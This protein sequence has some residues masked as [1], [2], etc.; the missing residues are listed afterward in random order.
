VNDAGT[1][2]TANT[3]VVF[4]GTLG[5]GGTLTATNIEVGAPTPFNIVTSGSNAFTILHGHNIVISGSAA[6][7]NLQ[8]GTVNTIAT[9]PSTSG[10]LQLINLPRCS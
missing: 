3:F 6:T 8:G 7:L 2:T 9:V 5:S 4:T 10:G 1:G